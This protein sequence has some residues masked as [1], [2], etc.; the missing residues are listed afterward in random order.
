MKEMYVDFFT[1]TKSEYS[2]G[3]VCTNVITLEYFG[4]AIAWGGGK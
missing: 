4:G 3:Q 1:I 2:L